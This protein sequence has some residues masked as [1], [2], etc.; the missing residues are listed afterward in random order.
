MEE[1][2]DSLSIIGHYCESEG[3]IPDKDDVTQFL[4]DQY[5]H[6]GQLFER[7]GYRPWEAQGV[8]TQL[9]NYAITHYLNYTNQ[10]ST[11][12]Q[13]I[14][15][16]AYHGTVDNTED[17]VSAMSSDAA[18]ELLPAFL[19]L[20]PHN[21][22]SR[23]WF[24]AAAST[25]DVV[26]LRRTLQYMPLLEEILS[27]EEQTA[28]L[29]QMVP[30]SSPAASHALALYMDEL[31]S[32]FVNSPR[33]LEY[34]HTQVTATAQTLPALARLSPK[35]LPTHY[36]AYIEAA[37]DDPGRHTSDRVQ[38]VRYVDQYVGLCKLMSTYHHNAI[39]SLSSSIT[40]NKESVTLVYVDNVLLGS[41]K[42][43]GDPSL[44]ALRS[45]QDD[46]GRFPLVAGGV[47]APTK[48]VVTAAEK[49][50]AEQGSSAH[51]HL[52][53]LSVQPLRYMWSEKGEDTILDNIQTIQEIRHLLE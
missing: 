37:M 38:S 40:E 27:D 46:D 12:E 1:E 43:R 18:I 22:D 49:A 24:V 16:T 30:D 51:L 14:Y 25:D 3:L 9:H 8:L 11:L 47:Y 28:M 52:D 42:S 17:N 26:Q 23:S 6:F 7:D 20:I 32:Q 34:L 21:F 41:L 2:I 53:T 15:H 50:V 45:V 33:F 35:T 39:E 13:L 48:A 5:V 44:L 4:E 36:A 29:T 10:Q 19:G 31:V